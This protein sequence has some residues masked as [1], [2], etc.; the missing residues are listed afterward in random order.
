MKKL[1]L[2]ILLILA[3]CLPAIS[4]QQQLPQIPDDQVQSL[5]FPFSGQWQPDV[6]STKVG[7]E[8]FITLQ[9]VRYD[10]N[11][12]IGV[13]GYSKINTTQITASP[14][15]DTG[16]HFKKDNPAE[17]HVLVNADGT[18]YETSAAIPTSGAF[19]FNSLHT[20]A[21]GAGL[22]RFSQ[23]PFGH[24]AY[25]NGVETQIWAGKEMPAAAFITSTAAVTTKPTNP[26]DYT[27][28]VNNDLTDGQNLAIIGGGIDT[29]TKLL[30]HLDALDTVAIAPF[31]TDTVGT[32]TPAAAGDAQADV[33]Q[34]KSGI[35]SGLFDG[36]GDYITIPDH[37]DWDMDIGTFT[38]DFW[39]RFNSLQSGG[40]FSQYVDGNDNWYAYYDNATGRIGLTGENNTLGTGG[41]NIYV[42]HTFALN[43]WYHIAFIR[44]WGG[45]ADKVAITVDGV[46]V[47]ESILAAAYDMPNLAATFEIGRH[48][49]GGATYFDGWIDE[50][51]VSKGITR[52][53]TTFVPPVRQYSASA[54]TWLVGSPR[55]L[56]GVKYYVQNANSTASTMTTSEWQG[57]SWVTLTAT[58][59]TDTGASLAATGTVT[60]TNT[61]LAQKKF[62]ENRLYYWYQFTI[63]AGEAT[64]YKATLDAPW[65]NL[66]DIWDGVL[67][68]PTQFQAYKSAK[69]QDYTLEV[70]ETD[71]TYYGDLGGMTNAEHLIAMFD[72]RTTAVKWVM[73]GGKEN[74]AAATVTIYYWNG[75]AWVSVGAVSDFT[76]DAAGGTKSLAQSGFMSWNAPSDEQEFYQTLFGTTGYAYK[77]MWSATLTASNA[78]VNTLTGIPAQKRIKPFRFPALYKDRL[79]LCGYS[80]GGEGNRCDFSQTNSSQIF[81]GAES[82][83][84]PTTGP[85]YFGGS[86]DLTAGA[87]LYNRMGSNI[88][89]FFLALKDHETYVLTGEGPDDFKIFPVSLHV[90]TPAPL[91]LVTAEMGFEIAK[92]VERHVAIWLS[93]TGP[94]MFD[95]AVIYQLPG[96]RSYFDPADDNYVGAANIENAFAWFDQQNKEYN[97]RVSTYWF[98][99][100]L[101]RKRWYTK[102]TGAAKMPTCAFPVNSTDGN[103]Y[104]Y[105]GT[106]NGYIMRLED[107]Y[108]WATVQIDHAIETGDFW[109]SKNIWDITLIDRF[110]YVGVKDVDV[111]NIVVTHYLDG[112]TTGATTVDTIARANAGSG[113][114]FR[115][116]SSQNLLGWSHRFKFAATSNDAAGTTDRRFKPLGWGIQWTKQRDDR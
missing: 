30:M 1:L 62:M 81:N 35:S 73:V 48:N 39:A 64:I 111:G 25:S 18:V 103:Q 10:N 80:Q 45:N 85:L 11:G 13:K 92:D 12:L 91:T 95:G 67:R 106:D 44:G 113:R 34:A 87:Q 65:Q 77:F 9:N 78:Q 20:D 97:L 102:D 23:A 94:V 24:V 96:I 52:W 36:N 76:L 105:A 100:D 116:T 98:I 60:W 47:K 57:N 82:S 7:P 31:I 109:P 54:K 43:T 99:Y 28:A 101:G 114:Y 3:L 26:K 86:E 108:S 55:Q 79:L 74:V 21:S 90:G 66:V 14:E 115:D 42:A 37:A 38:I 71:A 32:H 49:F 56:Q 27:E 16:F 53:A 70:N 84:N 59:N 88:F 17:T 4:Q 68:Q 69:Y 72:D 40:F 22:G 46:L 58:D 93:Y 89:I 110:K 29:Y 8:N 63:D 2:S 75:D 107:G 50:F 83:D 6:D 112:V 19:T 5:Y 15:L 104:I 61:G 41:I 33:D 51:R